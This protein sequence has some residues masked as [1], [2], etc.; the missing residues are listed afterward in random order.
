MY[1]M[2]INNVH[3]ITSFEIRKSLSS[4]INFFLEYFDISIV[5]R[6][7]SIVWKMYQVIK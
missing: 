3:N 4:L 7:S 2:C 1:G 5:A 6:I